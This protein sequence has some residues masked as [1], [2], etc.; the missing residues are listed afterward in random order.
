MK[1]LEIAKA[2]LGLIPTILETVKAVEAAIP[3]SGQGKQKFDLVMSTVES[4]YKLA[5][6]TLPAFEQ[7][8]PAIGTAI[9]SAVAVFNASG[10]F[11]KG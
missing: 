10:I 1:F 4:A 8:A 11:K 6:D 2:L 3:V 9:S 5:T 7:M